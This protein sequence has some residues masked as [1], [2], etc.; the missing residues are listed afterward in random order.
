MVSVS[1]GHGADGEPDEFVRTPEL[2][3]DGRRKVAGGL[4][5]VEPGDVCCLSLRA[6]CEYDEEDAV[7]VGGDLLDVV[8]SDGAV[9][10]P[11]SLF[12]VQ[13]VVAFA[14]VVEVLVECVPGMFGGGEY[15]VEHQ[16]V[17]GFDLGPEFPVAVYGPG[18]WGCGEWEREVK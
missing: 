18:H 10:N 16:T 5:G 12:D 8:V 14:L 2:P 9:G 17:L 6:T 3:A 7:Y 15:L 4:V 11:E 1:F 13:V